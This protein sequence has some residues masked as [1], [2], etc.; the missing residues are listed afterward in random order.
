[1]KKLYLLFILF[2][3]TAA[4]LAG[5]GT[6]Q[7]LHEPSADIP[8]EFVISDIPFY[9]QSEYQCG[10]SALA[11]VLSFYGD[12]ISPSG[13]SDEIFSLKLKGTLPLDMELF[14]RKRGFNTSSYIGS[15]PDIENNLLKGHPLILFLDTGILNWKA[16]HY[17]VV[18]GFNKEDGYIIVRWGDEK[19]K[20]IT[21]QNLLKKWKKTGYWT[22]LVTPQN[23]QI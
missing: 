4:N 19:E 16:G 1:M 9:P 22:L 11:T 6:I 5:C 13:I 2:L 3:L 20:R 18:T 12:S 17:I 14:P 7:K 23:G 15:I 21:Y 8:N 10:P